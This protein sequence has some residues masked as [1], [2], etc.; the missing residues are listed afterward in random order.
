MPI[1]RI[2]DDPDI[3]MDR[4]ESK[5]RKSLTEERTRLLDTIDASPDQEKRALKA[6]LSEVDKELERLS[7]V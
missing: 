2:H 1:N 3:Q 7:T 4:Y 6:R 5:R